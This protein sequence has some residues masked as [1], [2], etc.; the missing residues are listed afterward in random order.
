MSDLVHDRLWMLSE[1]TASMINVGLDCPPKSEPKFTAGWCTLTDTY[2][3]G[4]WSNFYQQN[5]DAGAAIDA[6]FP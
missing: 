6:A 1:V 5:E 2:A 3:V 4:L